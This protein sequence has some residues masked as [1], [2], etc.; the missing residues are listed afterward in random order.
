[1][2]INNQM[3]YLKISISLKF[4]YFKLFYIKKKKNSIIDKKFIL[5]TI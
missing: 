2:K 3:C 4:I 5:K 1:M